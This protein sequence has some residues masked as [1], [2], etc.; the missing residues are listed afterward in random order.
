MLL[1]IC[2]NQETLYA[3]KPVTKKMIITQHSKEILEAVNSMYAKDTYVYDKC[4]W[5]EGKCRRLKNIER[6]KKKFNFT[7]KQ[8]RLNPA[9][10]NTAGAFDGN[11]RLKTTDLHIRPYQHLEVCTKEG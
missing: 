1:T 8:S 11:A 3:R 7:I 4:K 10:R 5:K 2:K 9:Y 6:E